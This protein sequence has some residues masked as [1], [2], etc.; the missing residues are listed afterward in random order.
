MQEPTAPSAP[1]TVGDRLG[2]NRIRRPLGTTVIGSFYEVTYASTSAVYGLFVLAADLATDLTVVQRV[3]QALCEAPHPC[4]ARPYACGCDEGLIW[5][6]SELSTGVPL[7][8]F[9]LPPAPADDPWPLGEMVVHAGRLR[10]LF[11]GTVP[12]EVAWPILADLTEALAFLH[13]TGLQLG[14]MTTESV[15][16]MPLKHEQG[17]IAKWAGYGLI[18]VQNPELARQWTPR[19]DVRSV[20][21]VFRELLCG[22]FEAPPLTAW[23]EW[24][25]FLDR[26]EDTTEDGGFADGSELLEGFQALL[27]SKRIAWE[28][29]KTAEE[30]APAPGGAPP[31]SAPHSPRQHQRHKR[32]GTKR[33]HHSGQS[34]HGSAPL[35]I[36]P[37]FKMLLLFILIGVIGFAAYWFTSYDVR[38]RERGYD[39]SL[40]HR[41]GRRTD[42]GDPAP[43]TVASTPL[44]TLSRAE[45]RERHE[46]GD[47]IATLRLAFWT[48]Q[49]DD[50]T[51]P[52]LGA[53]AA[54]ARAALARPTATDLDPEQADAE[55]LYWTGKAFL[56]GLGTETD[57]ERGEALLRAAAEQH[58]HP[59]AM[60]LLGDYLA[61][62]PGAPTTDRDIAAL[63]LWRQA[64]D[65]HPEWNNHAAEVSERAIAFVRRGRGIPRG[66]GV[67]PLVRWLERLARRRHV[68]A[69]LS[70]GVFSLEGKLVPLNETQAMDWFRGAAQRGSPEGMR[71]MAWMFERGIGTPQS[72]TSAATW[73]QRAAEAGD[74]EAMTLLADLMAE[75]RGG[76]G[77]GDAAVIAEWRRRA[78]E[79]RAAESEPASSIWWQ[80]DATAAPPEPTQQ[81]AHLGAEPDAPDPHPKHP[82][83]PRDEDV[84]PPAPP[85]ETQPPNGP[86]PPVRP[87][88][89]HPGEGTPQPL[90]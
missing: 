15:V 18:E 24:T 41:R 65:A 25:S 43:Q 19:D 31:K 79:A 89:M 60:S 67:P 20:G 35:Q 11:H 44:D 84:P 54:L 68:S 16:F 21:A 76:P 61:F 70:L 82:T 1:L 36:G 13:H 46:S 14:P 17:V 88:L 34:D 50:Q 75:D 73:Y 47:Y 64:V 58:S 83:P 87:E 63:T 37:A 8:A 12:Q 45:L 86:L 5:I 74:A 26:T 62:G 32:I 78:A 42:T 53:G 55:V 3:V 56:T 33:G 39:R 4:L 38:Q 27:R 28:P 52:D 90:G 85:G 22:N 71:R 81:A 72:D 59:R 69:M 2:P 23:P 9:D 30:P 66:E 10:Q 6:R 29:R 7:K 80:A 51:G 40:L 49:G 57:A 77:A 48:A